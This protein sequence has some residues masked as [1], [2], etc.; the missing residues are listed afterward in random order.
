MARQGRNAAADPAGNAS[1]A[2]IVEAQL[3]AH[4]QNARAEI[5]RVE[6]EAERV[7]QEIEAQRRLQELRREL[8]DA[9]DA[10]KELVLSIMRN[11]ANPRIPKAL[12]DRWLFIISAEDP[13]AAM[14]E[15]KLQD[16]EAEKKKMAIWWRRSFRS[17]QAVPAKWLILSYFF[18]CLVYSVGV[19]Y[20]DV[21]NG[22]GQIV[23]TAIG[24][25]LMFISIA[26]LQIPFSYVSMHHIYVLSDLIGLI[27]RVLWQ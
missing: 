26:A 22:V 8:Q 2:Q 3:E 10:N 17:L 25:L 7:E 24:V 18:G 14:A 1:L 13:D 23:V 4:Q 6:Q 12:K 27:H 20:D 21:F 16:A 9:E 15:I 5:I 11:F 19:V